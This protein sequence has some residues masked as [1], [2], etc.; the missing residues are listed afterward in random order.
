MENKQLPGGIRVMNKIAMVVGY[1]TLAIP[2]LILLTSKGSKGGKV[3]EQISKAVSI[4]DIINK[5]VGMDIFEEWLKQNNLVDS[6]AIRKAFA[7]AYDWSML[8]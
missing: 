4:D 1:S 6:E 7:T 3:A 8:K 5:E 2:L